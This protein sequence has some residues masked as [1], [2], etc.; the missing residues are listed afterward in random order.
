MLSW[1]G[2]ANFVSVV[3]C[4]RR[5][6]KER[7]EGGRKGRWKGEKKETLNPI[8]GNGGDTTCTE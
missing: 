8:Q 1:F 5:R 2:G 6:E 3:K 4:I 7:R